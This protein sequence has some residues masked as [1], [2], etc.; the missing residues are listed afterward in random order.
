MAG[1]C[2]KIKKQNKTKFKQKSL[3]SPPHL[4]AASEKEVFMALATFL[5]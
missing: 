1:L 2:L 5:D 4:Q 3:R